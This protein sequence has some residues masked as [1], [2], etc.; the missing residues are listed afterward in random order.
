MDLHKITGLAR[1]A[2][3]ATLALAA[4]LAPAA[5]LADSGVY[6]GGGVGSAKIDDGAGDPAAVGDF[7]KSANAWKAFVGYNFDALPLIK[8][9]AE[10]GYRDLGKP[11]ATVSGVPVEYSVKGFDAGVMAGVGLGPVDLFAKV[12]GMQ[13]DLRKT[14]GGVNHD[15]D[16]T[17]PLY[18]IGAWLSLGSIGLRA[19]Y[20]KIDINELKD[21]E[22]IS[23]SAFYKF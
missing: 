21:V 10:A 12:G 6:I 18:G 2:C 16:G 13:Y 1:L 14:I 23:V 17:A 4:L 7:S 3:S 5:V 15:Y 11:S 19:E 22:M 9:A 20:E 8:F